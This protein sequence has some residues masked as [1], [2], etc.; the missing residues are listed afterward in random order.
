MSKKS[1]PAVIGGFVVGA[2]ALVV[3][4][5]LIV[6][7]GAFF[8]D[9][10]KMVA[11]FQGSVTGLTVGAPIRFNGAQVGTVTNI[12]LEEHHDTQP[13]TLRVA[14][15]MEARDVGDDIPPDP[16]PVSGEEEVEAFVQQ[17]MRAQLALQSLVT[18]QLYVSMVMLPDAS[19]NRVGV[20]PDI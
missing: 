9:T 2:L 3:A 14:V 10:I 8:V 12:G 18:G 5:I 15:F 20:R 6:G 13:P 16:E 11:Y 1:N 17:C 7:G 4:G 19:I